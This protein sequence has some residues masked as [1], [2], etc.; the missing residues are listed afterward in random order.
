MIR[1]APKRSLLIAVNASSHASGPG[2][3]G[4]ERLDLHLQRPRHRL[5]FVQLEQASWV[6]RIPKDRDTGR[7]PDSRLEQFHPLPTDLG[8]YARRQPGEVPTR[9]REIGDEPAAY[10]VR[11]ADHDDGNRAAGL[12]GGERVLVG[13]HDDHID[14]GADKRNRQLGKSLVL[15]FRDSPLDRDVLAVD[16][17]QL[18]ETFDERAPEIRDASPIIREN[19]DPRDPCRVLGSRTDRRGDQFPGKGQNKRAP[20]DHADAPAGRTISSAIIRM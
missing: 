15:P 10:W 4:L 7:P 2:P 16:V 5:G 19:A 12:L 13:R 3:P 1:S 6:A 20:T 11:D 9:A 17:P 14:L 8:A 18:L